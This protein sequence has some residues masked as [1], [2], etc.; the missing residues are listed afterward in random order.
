MTAVV[1]PFLHPAFLY[2]GADDYLAGTVPFILEG[3]AAG[4]PVAVV[5]PAP[6]LALIEAGLGDRASSVELI[7]MTEAGRNPGRI[8]P[9]VLLAFADA[10]RGPVRLIGEPVWPGRSGLEYPA[11]AQHE[12]L[13]NLAFEGRKATMLCP[14]DIDGLDSAALIDA[15]RTHPML[16]HATGSQASGVY[17]P[18]D[19]VATYNQPLPPPTSP[20]TIEFDITGLS[21]ARHFVAYHG[22]KGGLGPERVEDLT[23]AASELCA[24]SV[25]H[26]HGQGTLQMWSE[27]GFVVCEVS[28]HGRI[29]DLLAGRRPAAV[30]QVGGRGLLLVNQIADLVRMHHSAG[31]TTVRAYLRV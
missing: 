9:T 26:G 23:L 13:I 1:E 30:G 20:A 16:L 12:A 31:G 2:Q 17:A 8:L 10:H 11:C 22:A 18:T 29:T 3:L 6:N 21:A 14:Y 15:L 4:E 24:N 27:D 28:D 7:D 5:V 25:L 19:V